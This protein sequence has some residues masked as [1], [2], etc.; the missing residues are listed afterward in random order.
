MFRQEDNGDWVEYQIIPEREQVMRRLKPEAFTEYE[1]ALKAQVLEKPE[2]L[3]SRILAERQAK[4]SE[5]SA[6]KAG[7]EEV[8]DGEITR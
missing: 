7:I 4:L 2:E 8:L 6:A 1:N 3:G 5:I